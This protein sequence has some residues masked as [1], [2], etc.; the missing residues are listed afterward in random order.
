MAKLFANFINDIFL[1][2]Q[3]CELVN[4][5]ND[6]TMH[7][8]DKNINNAMTSLNHD[9]TVLSDWFNK[10]FIV[11]NPDKYSFTLFGVKD[12][13]QTDLVSNSI[14]T[15]YSKEGKALGTTFDNNLNFSTHLTSITKKANIKLNTL[16]RVQMYI[17]LGQK[18]LSSSFLKSQFN[19]CPIIWMYFSKE[20]LHRLNNIHE[21]SLPLIH[22]YISK[23]VTHLINATK[24]TI[25]QKSR[26]SQDR[27]LNTLMTYHLK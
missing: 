19:H 1:F 18:T 14:I 23:F 22:D 7:S 4:Y 16:T 5:A 2:L 20:A 24:K 15:R 12:E 21:R 27:R 10:H 25:L 26:V 6:S 11:L 9:F 13:L 8:S 17:T 3:K